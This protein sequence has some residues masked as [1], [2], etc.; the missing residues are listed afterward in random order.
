MKNTVIVQEIFATIGKELT[1]VKDKKIEFQFNCKH[2][3]KDGFNLILDSNSKEG[4]EIIHTIR[5]NL[6]DKGIGFDSGFN[7]GKSAVEWNLDWSIHR[8]K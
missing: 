8:C 5:K 7:L 6:I 3:G 1:K 2:F 4:T